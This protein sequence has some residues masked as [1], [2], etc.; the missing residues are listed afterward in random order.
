MGRKDQPRD[1]TSGKFTGPSVN[2]GGAP[3]GSM[4]HKVHGLW[5]AKNFLKTWGN[6]AIDR[7]TTVGKALNEW[8][9]EIVLDLGGSDNL[10]AQER[11]VL[12]IVVRLKLMLDSI[13]AYILQ[14][15]SLVIKKSRSVI[16]VIESA[17][18]C[19]TV[20]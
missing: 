7:R 13:D 6:Q 1:S 3:R 17:T 2:R 4:N 18:Y 15:K 12:D 19:P 11:A 16:P 5:A 20:L 9:D 14:Q 8:K 10:S